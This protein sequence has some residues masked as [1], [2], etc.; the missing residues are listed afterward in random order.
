M[1]SKRSGV[2]L[3]ASSTKL[4]E[5]LTG[6]NS[7]PSGIINCVI[8]RYWW[9]CKKSLPDLTT[10][11]WEVLL[12]VYTGCEMSSYSPPY[13]IGSDMMDYRGESDLNALEKTDPD[14]ATLVQ[15]MNALSQVQQ[16]AVLDFCQRFWSKSWTGYSD[17]DA[18]KQELS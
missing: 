17:F 18:I 5:S 12:N 11:E 9:A 15:K 8:E 6:V 2:Y 1:S 13:R 3:S 10:A 4:V 14:Y 7:S 16:M